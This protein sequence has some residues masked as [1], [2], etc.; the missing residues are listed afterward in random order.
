ME[1]AD[2]RAAEEKQQKKGIYHHRD[3]GSRL[4][5]G[6]GTVKRTGG[7]WRDDMGGEKMRYKFHKVFSVW[8]FDKEEKWLNE[9]AAKGLSLV[10][11]GFCTYTFE[12]G[13]PGAY[14]VR[15]E[16]LN[17]M[18]SHPKSRQYIEFVEDTGA[19]YIGSV[20][21]WVYFRKKAGENGF[22]LF[23]D[24]DSR[25]THLKR[26]LF[27]IGFQL[28]TVIVASVVTLWIFY[29]FVHIFLKYDNLKKERVL[30]E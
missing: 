15:L 16:L 28:F 14:N 17:D 22:D 23:S 12:E 20:F 3:G 9:M 5:S 1:Q 7:Q 30:H 8:N 27:S 21:R 25:I 19:E 10:S 13:A 2:N 6:T 4:Q 24:I 18:P 11:V 29:G 26:I